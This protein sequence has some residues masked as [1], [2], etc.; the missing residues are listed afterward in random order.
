MNELALFNYGEYPVRTVLMNGEVWFVAKDVCDVLEIKNPS[1]A[2]ADFDNDEKGLAKIYTPGGE[3]NMTV[4]SEPGVYGLVFRSSKPEAKAFSRW[5]KHEVLPKIHHTGSYSVRQDFTLAPVDPIQVAKAVF[6][7]AKIKDNQLALALDKVAIHYTGQSMLALAGI[8][9]VAPT[10][11]Q[12][13]NPTQIGKHFGVS[14]RKVNQVLLDI[15]Y[16]VKTDAGY[17]PTELGEPYA[18]MLDVNKPHSDGTPIR[19]LKWNSDLLDEINY[20]F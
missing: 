6:E 5:V 15:G 4:I 14:A 20:L 17:E 13:L 18:V 1:D 12:L 19:Q 7:A 3:Q 11:N 2:V 9:L 8:T 16:Q 10:T